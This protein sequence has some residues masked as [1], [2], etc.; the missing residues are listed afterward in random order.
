VSHLHRLAGFAGLD[1][2][3]HGAA[4]SRPASALRIVSLPVSSALDSPARSW[5]SSTA[6]LAAAEPC[7]G[8]GNY[9]AA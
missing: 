8:W 9:S 2:G 4:M 5:P 6:T 1:S 3:E 7:R